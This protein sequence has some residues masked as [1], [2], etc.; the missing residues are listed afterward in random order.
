MLHHLII[1]LTH[2]YHPHFTDKETEL[3][4]KEVTFQGHRNGEGTRMCMQT[5]WLPSFLVTTAHTASQ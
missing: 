3:E 1:L 4:S 2:D 5:A